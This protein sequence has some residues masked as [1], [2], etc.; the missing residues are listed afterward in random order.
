MEETNT[1]RSLIQ[2]NDL[3]FRELLTA[4]PNVSV[5]GYDKHRRVIYWNKASERLYGYSEQEAMGRLLEDLIIPDFMKLDVIEA[6]KTWIRTG[7]PIPSEEL[8]LIDKNKNVV[9]VYSSHVMLHQDTDD[10]EMFCVDVDL[11][12]QKKNERQL[13][14]LKQ[15]DQHTGLLNKHSL[16]VLANELMSRAQV[17]AISSAAIFVGIDDLTMIN[18]AFGYKA[19]DTLLREMVERLR[20]CV[21]DQGILARYSGDVFVFLVVIDNAPKYI[22]DVID[23]IKDVCL[24]PFRFDGER[25][26]VTVSGGVCIDEFSQGSHIELFKNAEV[27]MNQAKLTGK[28]Q[29]VYFESQFDE[30]M[31]RF[32][33]LFSAL[34]TA[35]KNNEFHM[36]YQ[37]QYNQQGQ[38]VSAEALLRW[39]HPKLGA[40][41]PAEFIPLAENKNKMKDIDLWVMRN[42]IQQ[43][44][45]WRAQGM[46]TVRVFMNISGQSLSDVNFVNLLSTQLS[47]A[48]VPYENVGIEITEYALIS[49]NDA[50]INQMKWLQ[51]RGIE[52]ALDDF[53]TGYSSLSYLTKF[54]LDYIKIDKYFIAHAPIKEQDAAIT[55]AIFALSESLGMQVICEGV[56][57]QTHLEF[58]R[59]QNRQSL[60]QGYLFSRPVSVH[61]FEALLAREVA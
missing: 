7:Q 17:D 44:K 14:Y 57:T 27:A 28:N 59:D 39:D 60:I 52:I 16:F 13:A 55:K 1:N 29:F 31:Q 30:N 37:P 42:V 21:T 11:S 32:H 38:I 58:V 6:H 46:S 5:Q 51:R 33:A 48:G 61:D 18:N 19:G 25:R 2:Q 20:H 43:I 8:Q 35:E 10:P 22:A 50:M 40:I 15:Y 24:T 26:Q 3:H 4:L 49:E 34:S 41:S 45:H 9:P 53:G 12:S 23:K 47:D 56:E 54:P 36:V